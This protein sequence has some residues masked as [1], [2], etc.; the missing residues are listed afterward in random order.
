MYVSYM[1][2]V[3]QRTGKMETADGQTAADAKMKITDKWKAPAGH[4][5]GAGAKLNSMLRKNAS[6]AGRGSDSAETGGRKPRRR[7]KRSEKERRENRVSWIFLSL[8]VLGVALFFVVPF[9][10]VIYYSMIDNPV[11]H[12]FVGAANYVKVFNN[13]A[14]RLAAF[15]TLKFSL[16]AV[17]LA[18]GLSL[19]LA[20]EMEKRL[21]WKSRLRSFFLSPMMV[22]TASVIMIWQIL[23]HYN[24]LVNVFIMRFG[25]G[26]IDW[27]KSGYA[28][29]PIVLLFLWKNIGYNMILFMAGLANIPRDQIEVAR[30]ESATEFQIFWMIKIRYLSSTILFVTIMSLINSFKVF[31]EIYLMAGDYPYDALYMLQHFMNNTFRSLDY[32]KLSAA[33]VMMAVFM[34]IV[35][36]AL[37]VTEDRFSRDL[38]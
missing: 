27:L 38:E 22:P 23:F 21:A 31:R 9:F 15:N 10:V 5:R 29:V 4:L 2:Y 34:I 20:V 14:F 13:S 35:I 33:A 26:K 28:Q 11:R 8:S 30:L 18:V 17:P 36:G 25:G 7:G 3:V 32:Q 1:P 6:G 37:F 12:N 24:G 16:T 19:L